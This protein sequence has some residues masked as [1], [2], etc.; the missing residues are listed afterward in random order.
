[1]SKVHVHTTGKCRVEATSVGLAHT[2]PNY[3]TGHSIINC[4]RYIVT[5][6]P[7]QC[8]TEQIAKW[9]VFSVSFTKLEALLHVLVY[10]YCLVDGQAGVDSSVS[11][12]WYTH[13]S[14]LPTCAGKDGST[15]VGPLAAGCGTDLLPQAEVP[16]Q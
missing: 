10:Q 5:I 12:D 13:Q 15:H 9:L 3:S 11:F 1:M 4:P 16:H 6:Y 14:L 2:H 8:H 7:W